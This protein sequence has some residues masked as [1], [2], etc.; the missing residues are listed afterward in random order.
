MTGLE[1]AGF[2]LAIPGIIDVIV[3]GGEVVYRKVEVFRR[4]HEVLNR[5]VQIQSWFEQKRS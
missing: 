2:A 4:Q 5:Y 3:R 1:G